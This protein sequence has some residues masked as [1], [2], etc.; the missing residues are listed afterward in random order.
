MDL[1][2]TKGADQRAARPARGPA[3]GRRRHAGAL[4]LAAVPVAVAGGCASS[5]RAAP[6]APPR[7][8]PAARR[9]AA[10]AQP[11]R[12]EHGPPDG[13]SPPPRRAVQRGGGPPRRHRVPGARSRGCRAPS[14]RSS[15]GASRRRARL[16]RR[17]RE[18]KAAGGKRLYRGILSKPGRM[19]CSRSA[20]C[21]ARRWAGGDDPGLG[22]LRAGAACRGGADGARACGRRRAPARV[23]GHRVSPLDAASLVLLVGPPA[24]RPG[25]GPASSR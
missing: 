1:Y 6:H 25:S 10:G 13:R 24:R 2:A 20:R 18:P 12:R 7:P 3:R 9:R 22:C 19:A 14:R 8:G 21:G 11:A 16:V 15:C 23:A 5:A 4:T 17:D